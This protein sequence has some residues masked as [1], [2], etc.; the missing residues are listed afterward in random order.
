[1]GLSEGGLSKTPPTV[2][3]VNHSAHSDHQILGARNHGSC[4]WHGF[5]TQPP[6]LGWLPW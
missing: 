6:T 4:S 5:G 2:Y 1:M 3:S